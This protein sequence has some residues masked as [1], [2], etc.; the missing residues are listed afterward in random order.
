MGEERLAAA[1][2]AAATHGTAIPASAAGHCLNGEMDLTDDG[3]A[4]LQ[5]FCERCRT[6]DK[7]TG[8]EL[9]AVIR[10]SCQV[11]SHVAGLTVV[12]GNW[13]FVLLLLL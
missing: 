8:N 3:R 1:A 6:A 2:V 13:L 4:S 10:S 5:K 12:T 11:Q 9:R 7:Q